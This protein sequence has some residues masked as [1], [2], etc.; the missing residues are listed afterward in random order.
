MDLN[1]P[2]IVSKL[3][4]ARKAYYN[5]AKPIMSDMEYDKLEELLRFHD[6]DHPYF[7]K[8]GHPPS[9]NWKKSSHNIPMGSLDK[10]NSIE[11]FQKW[12]EK[13]PGERLILQPKL[14]GAS[15][16]LDYEESVFVKAITRGDG[17]NGEDISNN[18]RLMKN[19]QEK[20]FVAAEEFTGSIR[21]EILLSKEAFEKINQTL[22]EGDK[23][24]NP[25]NAAAGICRGL[26]G[27]Y[28]RYLEL[29]AYNL[30]EPLDEDAK[31]E[32]LESLGVQSVEGPIGDANDMIK[33]FEKFKTIRDK[34]KV[35]LDGAVI[36][37]CSHEIQEKM[38]MAKNKPRAQIA[39][40]F[41]PPGAATIFLEES[42]NVGRTGVV[43]PLANLKPIE[44]DGSIISKATLHNIAEIERLGI[45]RGDIVMV[46]K[47]ND[48]IP[49][50][51]SII[52]H[53]GQPIQILT[54]C[55]SCGSELIN[56]KIK[57][58]CP[59]DECP[60]KQLNRILNWI[61]VTKI[62]QLGESIITK[63]NE[64][65]K[66]KRIADIYSL[67]REDISNLEG[68]GESS[69]DK[70]ISNI[71]S[72]RKI[73]SQIFLAAVGIP[74]ISESTSRDLLI[75]YQSIPA[76]FNLTVDSLKQLKGFSDISSEKV[77]SGLQKYQQEIT[78][79]LGILTITETDKQ[80]GPLSGMSFCFTGAMSQ[81]RSF[82]QDIVTKN[83]GKNSSTVGKDLTYL[84]CNE[85]KGSSKS[86]KATKYGVK[87][88]TE[89]E[90]ITLVGVEVPPAKE[91]INSFN[92]FE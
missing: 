53:K 22:P 78:E 45:G 12:A 65:G 40:K 7:E 17:I 14:D 67:S 30:T 26:D 3:M 58:R 44:I 25:R 69:A 55:P 36:K 76:L 80:G 81:P 23:Y 83:G 56:D 28:C 39:W 89:Q 18:V 57:L 88:I 24:S 66:I 4:E 29:I 48:I 51:E 34:F 50:I 72:S 16:S 15:L 92:L 5:D 42:W 75:N 8:I 84:V 54:H 2:E 49:I 68:W 85:D 74:G 82:Y 32:R 64:I 19:F 52:E 37:V 59:S 70:I 87:V 1:L 60:R 46:I 71:D 86:I 31:I 27:T 10:V 21:C 38:G 90:F 33:G 47:A 9:D 20:L 91:K 41:D 79:L 77:V 13:Y 11:E 62:D 6:K 43:T 63:L 73:P 61:K 35:N